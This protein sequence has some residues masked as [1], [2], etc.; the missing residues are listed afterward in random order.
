VRPATD[1]RKRVTVVVAG[2]SPLPAATVARVARATLATA[3]RPVVTLQV[4]WLTRPAMQRLHRTWKGQDR[5]TDVLS[6]ALVAPDGT[7]TGDVYICP[8][9]ARQQARAFGVPAREEAIRLVVHGAL[10][11]LGLDHPEGEARTRSAM[12]RAQERL[13]SRLA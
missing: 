12:W 7:I 2:R 3:R 4:T 9:V 10:H 5:P 8:A 13:V 6:F 11:V 1:R